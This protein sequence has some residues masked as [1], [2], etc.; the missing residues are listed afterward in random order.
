MERYGGICPD[1]DGVGGGGARQSN[2]LYRRDLP[3]SALHSLK[4]GVKKRG[5]GRLIGQT[6]GGMNTKLHAVTNT[7]GRPVR[8]FITVCQ[9][10]DYIRAAALLSSLPEAPG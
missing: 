4:P 9:V 7:S 1:Y 3:Q 10:S 8:L 5:R 6:K 2:D